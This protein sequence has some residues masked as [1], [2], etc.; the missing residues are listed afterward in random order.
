MN[1]D[2]HVH[3]TLS[4]GENSVEDMAQMGKR[5][6]LAGIGASQVFSFRKRAA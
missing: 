2:L 4:I 1:Y 5:L 6:G 3:T